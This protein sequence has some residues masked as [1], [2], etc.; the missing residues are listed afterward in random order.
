MNMASETLEK[1][2]QQFDHAPYPNQPLEKTVTDDR[3]AYFKHSLITP[4]YLRDQKV[5]TTE[6][7]LIL[8]AG[9]G[10]GFKAMCLAAAN[11]GA[12]ILGVDISEESVKLAR[13]RMEYHGIADTEFHAMAIEDLPQLGLQFDYI[14][15]DEVIYLLPDPQAALQILRSVLA[16]DGIIRVNVHSLY[17]RITQYRGQALFRMMGLMDNAPTEFE[18]GVVREIFAGLKPGIDLKDRGWAQE[19]EE[20]DYNILANYSLVGDRGYTLE[21]V[22]TMLATANLQLISM[23][24]W[25]EWS[26][27][28]LLANP[29]D[30]PAAWAM[31]LEM[32][33]LEEQLCMYDL[34]NP[35]HRLF[36]FWCG[37]PYE[38]TWTPISDWTEE[39]WNRAI[40]TLHPF[41][42]TD[43]SKAAII[44]SIQKLLPLE[45]DRKPVIRSKSTLDSGLL[46]LFLALWDGPQPVSALVDRYLQ[47]NP[48]HPKTMEPITRDRAAMLVQGFL[49]DQCDYGLVLLEVG[50]G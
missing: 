34:V 29:A 48:V 33:S 4:Y 26:L 32:A 27:W 49:A 47:L 21:E 1:I 36:D 8:D 28:D 17:Q 7:K 12:R 45:I 24:N 25:K 43:G 50:E 3:I 41:T 2:R 44:E 31:S 35:I 5:L 46:P 40:A 42:I 23:V 9:C 22:F 13:S 10:S 20:D 39:E 19:L 18:A 37:H 16:P 11:P 6:G 38:F 14:N 30:P 15:C